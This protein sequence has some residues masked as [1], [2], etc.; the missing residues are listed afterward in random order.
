MQTN[1]KN[2][3]AFVAIAYG[4]SLVCYR[5]NRALFN[6]LIIYED[7]LENP[8]EK[9]KE[10]LTEL[11]IDKKHVQTCLLA[12][13]KDSQGK[14]FGHTDGKQASVFTEK[15]WSKIESIFKQFKLPISCTMTL[16]EFK[17]ELLHHSFK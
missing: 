12:M 14:F 8:Q 15:Q 16:S 1:A 9:T 10:M 6:Q 11:G 4:L 5:R 7:L 2:L 17:A 3:D 13:N